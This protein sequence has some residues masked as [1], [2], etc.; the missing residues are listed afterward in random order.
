MRYIITEE[1]NIMLSVLRRTTQDYD[2]IKDIVYEGM[3]LFL[4]QA[5]SF[6]IYYDLTCRNSA[7]TYLLNYFDNQNQEGY[8]KMEDYLTD[9]IKETFLQQIID[10]WKENKELC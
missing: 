10:Y 7:M 3:D 9:F 2:L 1:Q 8:L 4:C 6:N 5:N